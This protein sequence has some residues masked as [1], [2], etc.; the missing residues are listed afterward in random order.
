MIPTKRGSTSDVDFGSETKRLRRDKA[1]VLEITSVHQSKVIPEGERPDAD[2]ENSGIATL[3]LENAPIETANAAISSRSVLSRTD[4][5]LTLTRLRCLDIDT[6]AVNSHLDE[7]GNFRRFTAAPNGEKELR[8]ERGELLV[9]LFKQYPPLADSATARKAEKNL[10]RAQLWELITRQ[11]NDAFGSRLEMLT[12][13]KVKKLLTYYKKKEEGLFDSTKVRDQSIDEKPSTEREIESS[14]PLSEPGS[15][16]SE[17]DGFEDE[18]VA[19]TAVVRNVEADQQLQN[20]IASLCSTPFDISG[21]KNDPEPSSTPLLYDTASQ[22]KKERQEFVIQLAD[23]YMERMC[24]DS[25]SRSAQVNAERNNM[26]LKIAKL[27]NVKYAGLL[28]P[29]GVEQT[30]KLFSNCKR[31]RRMREEKGDGDSPLPTLTVGSSS[32]SPAENTVDTNN[33]N[34]VMPSLESCLTPL[35]PSP[36]EDIQNLVRD[37]EVIAEVKLLRRELADRDAE[38]ARLQRKVVEQANDYKNRINSIADILK[39][40]ADKKIVDDVKHYLNVT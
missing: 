28:S 7:K 13:E 23:F 36:S 15:V 29:L 26:W 34:D 17:H 33:S 21:L 14:T 18:H 24:F 5:D 12:V 8:R 22:L 9:K 16:A 20:F 27:T 10:E 19:T 1:A 11:V 38:V 6:A 37:L 40:A 39:A 31:R 32:M 35:E 30:K 3:P 25:L 4:N 2:A